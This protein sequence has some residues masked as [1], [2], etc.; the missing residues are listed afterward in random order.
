ML[1]ENELLCWY[2]SN[3]ASEEAQAVIARIRSSDPA[4]RVGGGRRNVAA[5]SVEKD[6]RHDS[7]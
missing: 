3:G 6:A 2:S 1:T 5:V 4:R 7:V